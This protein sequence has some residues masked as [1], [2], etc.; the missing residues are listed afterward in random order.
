MKNLIVGALFACSL[1]FLAGCASS[2]QGASIIPGNDLRTIKSFYVVH[3]PADK[4]GIDK[5]IAD[6]LKSR[7]YSAISGEEGKT[8]DGTDAVVTYK[9]KWMWDIT[10]Y[11]IQLDIQFRKPVSNVP[12]ASGSSLRT[13]LVRKSPEGMVKEVLDQIFEKA[14]IATQTPMG[15]K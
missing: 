11:M 15:N 2:R 5:L 13:S 8:P 7:G 4:R 14:G 6:D 9:D 1:L 12:L 3:L 10:M